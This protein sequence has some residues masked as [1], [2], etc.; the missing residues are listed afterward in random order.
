M[1]KHTTDLSVIGQIGKFVEPAKAF[2]VFDEEF[3]TEF[4]S[5]GLQVFAEFRAC[6][7]HDG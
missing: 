1:I 6:L 5:G 4:S 7:Q 3:F 2:A